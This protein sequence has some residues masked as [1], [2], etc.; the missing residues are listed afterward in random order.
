MYEDNL[1]I[2]TEVPARIFDTWRAAVNWA[3]QHGGRVYT[4]TTEGRGNAL[5]LGHHIVN[6]M[7]YVVLNESDLN[8]S[9]ALADLDVIDMPDDESPDEYTVTLDGQCMHMAPLV[10]PDCLNAALENQGGPRL[11]VREN[12]GTELT[13]VARR[14]AVGG[15]SA[16]VQVDRSSAAPPAPPDIFQLVLEDSD[17]A[18]TLEL[19]DNLPALRSLVLRYRSAL[20][21]VAYELNLNYEDLMDSEQLIE[22][23][24]GLR[25]AYGA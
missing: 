7:Q 12:D 5:A 25:Q 15:R 9:D 16:V 19:N 23:V 1:T 6:A 22:R 13:V 18:R 8:E 20:R 3:D 4:W 21:A 11:F 24:H 14:S 2:C 17:Y 10:C